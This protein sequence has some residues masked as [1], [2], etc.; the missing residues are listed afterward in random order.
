MLFDLFLQMK[1]QLLVLLLFITHNCFGQQIESVD[2]LKCEAKLNISPLEKLVS[3]TVRYSFRITTATDSVFID[4]KNMLFDNIKIAG[5][6]SDY[7]ASDKKLW[8]YHNFEKGEEYDVSFNYEAHPKKAMYFID[9]EHQNHSEANP[10]VWTQGQ[11]KDNSNWIP[12]FDDM[13]EKVEFD[14]T[15]SFNSNYQVLANG[16]LLKTTSASGFKHWQY[17]MQEPMSSYLLAIAIGKYVKKEETSKSG[18]PLEMYYYPKDTAKVE[19]TYRYTKEIFD[20]LEEE[21]GVPYPWQNYKQLPVKDFLYAGMEN[22][23]ITLF[24]DAFMTDS[25]AFV[26]KNYVNVNAHELAHQWFGDLITETHGTHHW[27]QEGFAT[28]YALLAEKEMF[29]EDYYYHRLFE[30]SE[31]LKQAQATDT[32]PL[33]NPKASSLTFYQKGAWALHSLREQVGD[34]VFKTSVKKYVL[35]HQF[36]NVSTN[37]FIKIV[38]Q[39]SGQN[40]T[41]FVNTWLLSSELPEET[42]K[43]SL[44]RNETSAFL[45]THLENDYLS[46]RTDVNEKIISSSLVYQLPENS[47]YSVTQVVLEELLNKQDYP[48]FNDLLTEAFSS[49]ELKVR[50]V[51]ADNFDKIPESFKTDFNNLLNDKSYKTIEATLFNLWINV[52]NNRLNNLKKTQKLVGFSD[53]NIRTLWLALALNTEGFKTS[54]YKLFY[55]ELVSYT[56]PAYHFEVRKNAFQY[57]NELQLMNSEAIK[58]LT[59][60][61]QHHNWRFKSYCRN[62]LAT[63]K[64]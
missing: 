47:H 40:L 14:I 35:K 20:F 17:D 38:E 7:K 36:K 55:S 2:F 48:T 46:Y 29:G 57:L 63:F 31:Q 61:T 41:Q 45:Q 6:I 58:N 42:I 1:L 13:N 37:D 23:S 59:N 26:D 44:D 27:L 54:K 39:E 52:P 11:G 62:L 24:S 15:V 43:K 4:A 51:L 50:Q 9:W 64:K 3:G 21:I 16:K 30:N 5:K 10:Q 34:Q 18:I 53:K 49:K 19:P 8:L 56:H 22:T 25:I 33:Q 60:A 28:Y 12:S 32:I